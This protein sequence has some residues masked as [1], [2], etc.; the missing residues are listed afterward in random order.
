MYYEALDDAVTLYI[1]KNGMTKE[2]LAREMGMAPNTLM[3]K[4]RGERDFSFP[5]M[6]RLSEI[7]GI[8]SLDEMVGREYQPKAV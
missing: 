1:K 3:W 2:D 6:Q 5:E 7:V 8:T 4:L